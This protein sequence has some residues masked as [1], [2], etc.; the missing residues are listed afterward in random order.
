ML[1]TAS[2]DAFSLVILILKADVVVGVIS[3]KAFVHLEIRRA[4]GPKRARECTLW[5][6]A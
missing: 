2:F 1:R 5:S 3:R 6:I 4:F